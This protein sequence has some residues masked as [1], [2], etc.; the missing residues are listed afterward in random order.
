MRMVARALLLLAALVAVT[1]AASKSPPDSTKV[2]AGAKLYSQYCAVC[3]GKT[4]RGDGAGA[5]SLKPKPR[6]FREPKLLKCKTDEDL[7]KVISKGGPALGMSSAMVGWG[8]IL[9]EPQIR[10]V[11]AFVRSIAD[12]SSTAKADSDSVAARSKGKP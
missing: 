10:Q 12:S 5:A 1:A 11:V 9:K 3:H 7:F 6:N 2:V 8:A 4:G